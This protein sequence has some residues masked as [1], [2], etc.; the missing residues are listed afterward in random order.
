MPE[1][2][3]APP[4][5]D[6]RVTDVDGREVDDVT[7]NWLAFIALHMEEENDF[8][9]DDLLD[10]LLLALGYR[11]ELERETLRQPRQPHVIALRDTLERL[12]GAGLI[13]KR[14]DPALTYHLVHEVVD[15][16]EE[17]TDRIGTIWSD[18]GADAI[19]SKAELGWL[20][21]IALR[22]QDRNQV[23]RDDLDEKLASLLGDHSQDA[24]RMALTTLLAELEDYDYTQE[25]NT[26][27]WRRVLGQGWALTD[28]AWGGVYSLRDSLL[29][30][31]AHDLLFEE[32]PSTVR[33]LN[34]A[35]D[36][37][38]SDEA[39][40]QETDADG[41]A[42][43]SARL[44][45]RDATPE[46]EE[47]RSGARAES[48]GSARRRGSESPLASAG[49]PEAEAS[50]SSSPHGEVIVSNIDLC[51][52]VLASFI[53]HQ[54]ETLSE[55]EIADEVADRLNVSE[56]YRKRPVPPWVH[57]DAGWLKHYSLKW[58]HR[59]DDESAENH[60]GES[61]GDDREGNDSDPHDGREDRRPGLYEY[62]LEHVFRAL[63]IAQT[64]LIRDAGVDGDA[65]ESYW[66][67]SGA[68]AGFAELVSDANAAL[69]TITDMLAP[70]NDRGAA[71]R[72][73]FEMHNY[74]GWS[75]EDWMEEI[76]NRMSGDIGPFMF[77]LLIKDVLEQED[78]VDAEAQAPNS[79][80]DEAGVDV[81]VSKRI[82]SQSA[83][84]SLD[85]E[86]INLLVQCKRHYRNEISP[87]AAA[88]L[89]ATT[90]W[91]RGDPKFKVAGARLA[92]FGDL[93]REA[94][95][96]F[97]ALKSAWDV[98]E[99]AVRDTGNGGSGEQTRPDLTWEIW[100]G[101]RVFQ[102]MKE[103]QV[104]VTVDNGGGKETVTVD[105]V[106]FK[107]LR[108]AAASAGE[109]VRRKKRAVAARR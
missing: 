36:A 84:S 46:P 104:G 70:S 66:S 85:P 20:T 43:E 2:D 54:G 42:S 8:E 28:R 58:L 6:D 71:L 99:K 48:D 51:K 4:V 39:E 38:E 13:S 60:E 88:K 86:R 18:V 55:R 73:Y 30:D 45:D 57:P 108:E 16:L 74:E 5:D 79:Y 103:R 91:L 23:S 94:T 52:A 7:L 106:Y 11:D 72:A 93:S 25:S 14:A 64:S 97:W 59:D 107:K 102:L 101:Q 83:V 89:F 50:V 22:I 34:F 15:A 27:I 9:D 37:S 44:S 61:E 98:M 41:D 56:D 49:S 40:A 82:E 90:M 32:P 21:I 19:D 67:I 100:D 29:S 65:K 95:W 62:R 78:G 77:E 69:T 24:R 47:N 96:T 92:F 80:L 87:D 53:E 35:A 1:S 17:V 10:D 109:A 76:F 33:G 26:S 3:A 81:V 105:E 12:E 68:L 31:F 75:P 63:S